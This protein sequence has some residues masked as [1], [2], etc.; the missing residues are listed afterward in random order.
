M[1]KFFESFVKKTIWIY[2]P[3]YAIWILM[4]ELFQD[5]FSSE[6]K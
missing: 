6:K 5:I 3:F 4:K 2:L 1:E